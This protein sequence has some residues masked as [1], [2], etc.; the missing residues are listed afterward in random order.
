MLVWILP[1]GLSR[2]GT[3]L[4]VSAKPQPELGGKGLSG[5]GA[6][7]LDSSPTCCGLQGVFYLLFLSFLI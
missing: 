4:L 3:G 5:G 7:F 1:G 2:C 6:A